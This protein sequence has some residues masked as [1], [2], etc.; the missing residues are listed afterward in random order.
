MPSWELPRESPPRALSRPTPCWRIAPRCPASPP[1]TIPP[2]QE[3]PGVHAAA[4]LCGQVHFLA[5]CTNVLIWEDAGSLQL[6]S[7]V[8]WS[9]R[10]CHH[11]PPCS[12]VQWVEQGGQ[13]LEA[14]C[15]GKGVQCSGYGWGSRTPGSYS[16]LEGVGGEPGL[17]SFIAHPLPGTQQTQFCNHP[18]RKP[19]PYSLPP[20]FPLPLSP[21]G[22]LCAA[23]ICTA[24][25]AGQ[26]GGVHAF[27][28][29]WHGVKAHEIATW[30]IPSRGLGGGGL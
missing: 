26:W 15:S 6:W 14:L 25:G 4:Q 2:Q 18:A 13:R 17:L 19:W 27:P 12:R 29:A 5:A 23:G 20:Q 11:C 3:T 24:P 28:G 9:M 8:V 30:R 21:D 7:A 10:W 1:C 16:S 22:E